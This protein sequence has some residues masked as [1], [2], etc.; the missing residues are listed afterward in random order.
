MENS[1]IILQTCEHISNELTTNVKNS[2]VDNISGGVVDTIDTTFSNKIKNSY[3]Q[4][5]TKISVFLSVS[6]NTVKYLL[7]FAL[8]VLVCLVA[9]HIY[10]K[11]FKN[12]DTQILTISKYN[13]N[14]NESNQ[15]KTNTDTTNSNNET[16]KSKTTSS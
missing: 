11:Y 2:I 12:T 16:E 8:L 5:I 4:Y 9:Y 1:D 6:E 7:I 13:S 15:D 3:S 14:E 10:K